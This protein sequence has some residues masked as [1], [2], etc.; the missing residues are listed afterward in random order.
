M[1]EWAKTHA[2][3]R[4]F[5]PCSDKNIHIAVDGEVCLKNGFAKHFPY[6]SFVLD[7]SHLE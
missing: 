3:K 5:Y 7:I 2:K 4:D 1:L 6:A